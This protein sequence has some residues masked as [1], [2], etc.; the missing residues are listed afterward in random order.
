[1]DRMFTLAEIQPKVDELAIKLHAP[2]NLL[3]TY[4]RTDDGARPYIEVDGRRYHF[5]VVER[6]EEMARYTTG[7]IDQLLLRGFSTITSPMSYT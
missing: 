6:G 4:G 5:V 3:P 7:A 2:A 1:M